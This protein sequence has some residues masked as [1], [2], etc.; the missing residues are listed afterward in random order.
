MLS[1]AEIL[2]FL[3]KN[4]PVLKEKYHCDQ[5][6]LFGSFV[7]NDQSD[8]SDIDILVVFDDNIKNMYD[9]EIS[10]R[11]YLEKQFDR[12]VDIC[13]KKWINPIF[14]PL[15]LKETVYA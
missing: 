3:K 12:K 14:K 6:G 5:I 15:I 10:L 9:T 13:V 8:S 11:K 4:K 1:S 2:D 7:R